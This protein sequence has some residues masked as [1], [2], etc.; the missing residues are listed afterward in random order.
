M[1]TLYYF[2]YGSNMLEE[3]F[4]S[5][6]RAPSAKF[7]TVANLSCY[8]LKFHK[9]SED[10]SGKC[11]IVETGNPGDEI[12]GVVYQIGASEKEAL[13]RMEV[14]AFGYSDHVLEFMSPNG[15]LTAHTYMAKKKFIDD[16]L[17]PYSWY[18]DIVLKGARQHLLPSDYIQQLEGIGTR[19]DP[20]SEREKRE[21]QIL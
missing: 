18:R 7:I 11:N 4:K 6:D 15:I 5:P 19:E 17:R 2:A 21:R 9:R 13:D 1:K 14:G 10:G 8:V 16:S 12:F 3:R 20:E